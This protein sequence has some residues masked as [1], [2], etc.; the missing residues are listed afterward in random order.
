MTDA[1]GNTVSYSYS[2]NLLISETKSGVLQNSYSYDAARRMTSQSDALGNETQY[3]YD[4]FG[5]LSASVSPEGL[6]QEFAYSENNKL[7][8]SEKIIDQATS[9]LMQTDYDNLDYPTEIR[10]EIAEGTIAI[11]QLEYNGNEQIS[12]TI[13][14]SGAQIE[15]SYDAQGNMLSQTLS[16]D[17]EELLTSYSYDANGNRISQN[18]EGVITSYSYDLFDRL[19][20]M[21][22]ALGTTTSYSY[23]TLGNITHIVVKDAQNKTLQDITRS[24]NER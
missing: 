11:T 23:N 6:R 13:L 12:K 3:E 18:R 1:L 8:Q 5:N 20:S 21:T 16:S 22:D 14:P 15:Y 7:T 10:E 9:A 24:Y 4:S 2:G 19:R 17:E